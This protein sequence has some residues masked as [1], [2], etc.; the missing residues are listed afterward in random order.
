[1][2]VVVPDEELRTAALPPPKPLAPTKQREQEK[3][4]KPKQRKPEPAAK[5]EKSAQ[6]TDGTAYLVQVGSFRQPA[7]AERLKAKLALL[8]IQAR[9]QRVTVNGKTYHRVRAGP[10]MGKQEVNK[11]RSLLSGKGL[12]SITVKLK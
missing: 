2:E 6:A 8:G 1:M 12:E 11:T 5:P 7:D 9:I 4:A 3:P 10:F